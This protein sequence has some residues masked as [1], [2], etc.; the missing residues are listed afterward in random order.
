MSKN[1][2]SDAA[3]KLL[4][5]TLN[6]VFLVKYISGTNITK[7]FFFLN[8]NIRYSYENIYKCFNG[9]LFDKPY[10]SLSLTIKFYVLFVQKSVS[11]VG[12]SKIINQFYCAFTIFM[13]RINTTIDFH[14]FS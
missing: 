8:S 7:K 14:R 1:R 10:S 13:Q 4:V 11:Y 9:T 5:F 12:F 3:L 6:F 2:G